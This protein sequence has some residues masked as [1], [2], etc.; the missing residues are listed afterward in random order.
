MERYPSGACPAGITALFLYDT[1]Y[2]NIRRRASAAAL[3]LF[4]YFQVSCPKRAK[5]PLPSLSGNNRAADGG[6]GAGV[7]N[8]ENQGKKNRQA[9][10]HAAACPYKG[11][12]TKCTYER[13]TRGCFFFYASSRAMLSSTM[14][15]S[16]STSLHSSGASGGMVSLPRSVS[17]SVEAFAAR[18]FSPRF[19]AIPLMV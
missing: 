17:V 3:A 12:V 11:Q 10:A 4:P 18:R 1:L 14:A 15:Q 19:S 13:S 6:A 7:A 2:T 8:T 5:S 9:A 16:C